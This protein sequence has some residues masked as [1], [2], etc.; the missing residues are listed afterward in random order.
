MGSIA[1]VYDGYEETATTILVFG[2][3]V[4][5]FNRE[6][7]NKLRGAL[8]DPPTQNQWVLD[9]V[10]GLPKYWKALTLVFIF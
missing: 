7:L 3:Q 4:L 1:K 2:P 8:S 9:T 10:A 5:S 6:A